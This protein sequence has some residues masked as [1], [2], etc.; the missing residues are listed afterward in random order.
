V[1]QRWQ[2]YGHHFRQKLAWL[3]EA[4]WYDREEIRRYQTLQLRRLIAHCYETVPYYRELFAARGLTPQD[5]R[6]PADLGK[7]PV[8]TKEDVR[9]NRDRLLSTKYDRRRLLRGR[10]SGTSGKALE[11]LY[12]RPAVQFQWAVWWR[13]RARFGLR[14]GDSFLMFGVRQAVPPSQTKPPFWRHNYAVQQTYLSI[15]HLTPEFMPE[16]AAYLNRSPFDFYTGLPAAMALLANYMRD[17]DLPLIHRPKCVVGG[18]HAMLPFFEEVLRQQWG[19]PVTEQ[20]GAAEC[21]ANLSKCERGV[22]HED[23][24]FGIVEALDN[25]A[26]PDGPKRIVGTG[27]ANPALP[28]LRYDIGDL[29]EFSEER[30]PCGRASRVVRKIDGRAEDY[31][32]TPDGRMLLG[33]SQVFKRVRGVQ[34]LQIVQNELARIVVKVVKRADYGPNDTAVL[35]RG[36]RSRLG[37]RIQIDLE[38]VDHIPRTARGKF[39]AV[40]STLGQRGSEVEKALSAAATPETA[41]RSQS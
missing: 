40:V 21:C 16:I 35:L 6:E 32:R 12:T 34:E 39:R 13:H 31:L 37:D 9:H 26:D 20:Y 15:P 1:Q 8:L 24:E 4:E 25:P 14:L 11:L 2:R 28:L 29:G 22:F 7:L 3:R 27:F 23:Y 30:C 17:H 36:L 41:S 10:T 19:A 18:S 33:V 5:I 38:F